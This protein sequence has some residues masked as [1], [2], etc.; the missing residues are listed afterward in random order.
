M[1][2]KNYRLQLQT[3]S[4]YAWVAVLASLRSTSRWPLTTWTK[5]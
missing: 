5:V 1:T 4:K 2:K 3:A